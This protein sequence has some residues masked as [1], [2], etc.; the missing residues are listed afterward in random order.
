MIEGRGP[1]GGPVVQWIP[2]WG[3]KGKQD[4]AAI[5]AELVARLGKDRADQIAYGNRN[6]LIFPNLIIN[7]IM[8]ITVR[9]FYPEQPDFVTVSSWALA[10]KGES[11][12][13]RKRRLDNFLEFLGPGGFATP[14]DVE[15]L[16]ACQRGYRNA[17]EAGWNDISRGMQKET[18][19]GDDEAQMRAFW[20]RWNH[21]VSGGF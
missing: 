15:A 4:I 2:A 8:A 10:P 12:D 20:R 9:T 5:H 16:E 14:D 18:P 17:R 6:L 21:C 1:W 11:R 19:A 13:F 3:E 7:D